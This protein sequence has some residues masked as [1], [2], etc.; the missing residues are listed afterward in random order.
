MQPIRNLA[1]ILALTALAV[2]APGQDSDPVF[3]VDTELLEIEVRV[4]DKQGQPVVGLERD[5]FTLREGGEQQ[6]ISTF[7]FIAESAA[8]GSAPKDAA[9]KAPDTYLYLL[10]DAT[11]STAPRAY[12]AIERFLDEQWQPGYVVAMPG[13]PFTRDRDRA[14]EHLEALR[15]GKGPSWRRRLWDDSITGD[16]VSRDFFDQA[17]EG[18]GE[19]APFLANSRSGIES[20]LAYSR[21]QSIRYRDIVQQLGLFSGKKV[22]V[23]F[24]DGL[25]IEKDFVP[26]YRELASEA[27]RYRVAFYT[28][29]TRGIIPNSPTLLAAGGRARRT[30]LRPLADTYGRLDRLRTLTEGG[31]LSTDDGRNGLR[32]L[33]E[34]SGGRAAVNT[35]DFGEVF[36]QVNADRYGYYLV[37][38]YPE[39]LKRNNRF[40][41]I[42]VEVDRPGVRVETT[43]GYFEPTPFE[44]SSNSD[45]HNHL[46]HVINASERFRDVPFSLSY[47][48]FRNRSG[49]AEATLAVGV[50]PSSLEVAPNAQDP[51]KEQAAFVVMARLGEITREREPLYGGSNLDLDVPSGTLSQLAA[52][53]L[54][55]FEL[56][57]SFPLES[58]QESLRVLVR[59]ELSGKI[60]AQT[61]E[62]GAPDLEKPWAPSSVLLTARFGQADEQQPSPFD[63]GAT[64]LIPQSQAIF[65]KGQEIFILYDLYNVEEDLVDTLPGFFVFLKKGAETLTAK[66]EGE[67]SFDAKAGTVRYAG[68]LETAELEPGVYQV[69]VPAPEGAKNPKRYLARSF[70]VR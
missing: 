8:P 7:D 40:R 29:D 28:A 24:R 36:N 32:T 69:L 6:Q 13:L 15:V 58:G 54:N 22:I 68:A 12:Q 30:P 66:Y 1:S 9:A 44:D 59:D 63:V 5:A 47:E 10:S 35:N 61:L 64:R 14:R 49:S 39:P 33:A 51:E 19:L 62:F 11:P 45:R 65:R 16:G 27:L 3:R 2:V 57:R 55:R 17:R 37:G 21:V 50:P 48:V 31:E 52:D 42:R 25:L 41:K 70:Q 43:D 20:S 23:L 60:G 4:L 46:Y 18:A 26:W 53:R 56:T 67:A 34:L 38:Y